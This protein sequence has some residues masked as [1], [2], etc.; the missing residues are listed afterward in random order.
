MKI[1]FNSVLPFKSY[2]WFFFNTDG[3]TDRQT[4][5]QTPY[6]TNHPTTLYGAEIFYTPF[7]L[8]LKTEGAHFTCLSSLC[9]VRMKK[10]NNFFIKGPKILKNYSWQ[11]LTQDLEKLFSLKVSLF[12]IRNS[13]NMPKDIFLKLTV[14]KRKK[15]STLFVHFERVYLIKFCCKL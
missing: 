8:P 12:G 11:S 5:T 2:S 1:L 4:D 15:I 6:K 9:F 13:Q 14:P 7:F 3:Q 10:L